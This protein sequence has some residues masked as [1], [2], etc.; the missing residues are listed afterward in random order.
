[1]KAFVMRHG[2][3]AWSVSGRH[4]KTTDHPLTENGRRLAQK[5]RPVLAREA[6]VR[7][8]VSPMLRTRETW[9]LAGLG[10]ASAI[11]PDLGRMELRRLR[12]ADAQADPRE[13]ARSAHFPGRLPGWRN[14]GASGCK[15]GSSH[16][17]GPRCR[18]Q[19]RFVRTRTRTP[20]LRGTM[21]R[22]PAV[23]RTAFPARYRHFVR[24]VPLLRTSRYRGLEQIPAD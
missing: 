9:A 21:D 22:A 18:G 6:F 1:M 15:G 19:C 5:L 12:G 2:E 7:V 17:P 3:T 24:S 8:F 13:G 4:T 14:A 16:R 11:D 20:R 10:N 23:R